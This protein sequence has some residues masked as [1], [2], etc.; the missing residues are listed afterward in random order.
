MFWIFGR[1]QAA[2]SFRQRSYFRRALE[3]LEDRTVPSGSALDPGSLTSGASTSPTAAVPPAPTVSEAAL[4]QLLSSLQK[5]GLTGSGPFSQHIVS[6][7]VALLIGQVI[8]EVEFL[9]LADA[10]AIAQ[11]AAS[12]GTSSSGYTVDAAA[13]ATAAS[14]A[15]ALNLM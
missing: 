2:R 15:L 3:V 4:Q 12:S 9:R 5:P 11:L 13:A 10:R 14:N 1:K 7:E 8:N 6:A